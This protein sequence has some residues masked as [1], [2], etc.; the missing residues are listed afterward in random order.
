MQNKK[1]LVQHKTDN[2]ELQDYCHFFIHL[3][4]STHT[5]HFINYIEVSLNVPMAVIFRMKVYKLYLECLQEVANL[6]RSPPYIVT[7]ESRLHGLF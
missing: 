1:L 2:R 5:N 3:I 4:L 7:G 6:C